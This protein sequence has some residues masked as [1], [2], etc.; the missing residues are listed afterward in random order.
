MTQ[1]HYKSLVYFSLHNTG[2]SKQ[3]LFSLDQLTFALGFE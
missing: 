2:H 1:D 3:L